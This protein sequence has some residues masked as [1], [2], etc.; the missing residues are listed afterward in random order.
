MEVE[1]SDSEALELDRLFLRLFDRP[2]VMSYFN[3]VGRNEAGQTELDFHGLTDEAIDIIKNL[4]GPIDLEVFEYEIQ[5]QDHVGFR[6]D[7]KELVELNSEEL[8][9][10]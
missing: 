1:A 3:K 10:A 8:E 6:F 5:A 2:E 9:Q 7:L 4:I